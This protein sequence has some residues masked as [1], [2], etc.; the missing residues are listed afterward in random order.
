M[1]ASLAELEA[2]CKELAPDFK[3]SIGTYRD[4]RTPD[5]VEEL[6]RATC[7]IDGKPAELALITHGKLSLEEAKRSVLE[8]ALATLERGR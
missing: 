5:V 1:V 3:I 6:V 8:G 4:P 2:R 7:T